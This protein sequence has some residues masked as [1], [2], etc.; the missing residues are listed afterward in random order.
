MGWTADVVEPG[1]T[2]PVRFAW[3]PVKAATN[4]KK[5]GVSFHEAASVF[6]DTLSTTFPDEEH[7][8]EDRRALTIGMSQSGKLLVVAHSE[9]GETIRIIS[10]RPTTRRERGFYEHG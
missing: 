10:A 2:V 6:K 3:D 9:R 7:S 4:L 1:Y 8:K 5:H